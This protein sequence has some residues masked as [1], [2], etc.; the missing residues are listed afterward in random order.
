MADIKNIG[1][2]F[3]EPNA[4]MNVNIE[5]TLPNKIVEITGEHHYKIFVV[6]TKSGNLKK[7]LKDG[8]KQI[9]S[10]LGK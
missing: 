9:L 10:I 2:V 8:H 6:G 3:N 7:S 5:Y 1:W 4:I